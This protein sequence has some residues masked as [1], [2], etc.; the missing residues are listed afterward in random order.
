M[1]ATPV[2]GAGQ[3]RPDMV[4][5]AVVGILL[6][7]G[8]LMV[9]SASIAQGDR[10][11]GNAFY[12]FERQILAAV[13]GLAAAWCMAKIPTRLWQQS[14]PWLAG[15]AVVLLIMQTARLTLATLRSSL[16]DSSART[17]ASEKPSALA[18]RMKRS[19]LSSLSP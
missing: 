8:L 6:A 7:V 4:L 11:H 2:A 3:N 13:M 10:L 14:G 16:S 15:A 9:A 1:S 12:F 17:S 5:L 19:R 18:R